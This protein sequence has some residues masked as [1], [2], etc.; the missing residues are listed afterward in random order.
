[1]PPALPR[2][3]AA[4]VKLTARAPI[5]ARF[6]F[7]PPA[8]VERAQRRRVEAAVAHAVEHVPYYRET[9][10]RL[11]LTPAD[12]RTADD[13]AKLPIL[14]RDQFQRDPEYFLSRAHPRDDHVVMRTSGSTGEPIE[15]LRD[16]NGLMQRLAA[17]QRMEPILATL[18]GKRWRRR[19]ALIA[20][21]SS[22]TTTVNAA[23]RDRVLPAVRTVHRTFN[24]FVPPAELA[25]EVSAFRPDVVTGYGSA[26]EALFVEL[27]REG[28]EPHLP[29][30]A[31]FA[32]DVLAEPMRRAITAA[33]VEV[34]SVYQAVEMPT[35]GF[36]C[37]AHAGHHLN[38]DFCP[39]RI[40][41]AD[42][43]DLP[44]EETGDVV[45]SNLVNRG[46]VLL[47]YRLGDRAARLATE[48][49][50]G[51]TLP[52]LSP[53]QGRV[54]E[55]LR[56]ASGEP[57]HPQVL[58]SV[59]RKVPGLLRY[60]LEQDRPGFVRVIAVT[61]PSA[62]TEALRAEV[63]NAAD[64]LETDVVFTDDLPREAGGKVR[65]LRS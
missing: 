13:L 52:L 5:E 21:T 11:G 62:D 15:F 30:V 43:R 44:A 65:G 50:C 19:H 10:R 58:R 46:T 20:P 6:P 9:M 38:V 64:G 31:I 32:A 14:E 28:D 55:W 40:V 42:G 2:R 23:T 51:R 26:I 60:T 59:L 35:I 4:T 17:F 45:T 22:S 39:L 24:L 7:R 3:F 54:S 41:D 48:C 8:A 33:G 1:M 47:N 61:A 12:L 27:L 53:V 16:G 37:E 57:V 34:L 63:A 29:R 36:E 49:A 56:T 25:A 18:S